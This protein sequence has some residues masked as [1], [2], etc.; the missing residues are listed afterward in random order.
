M[1]SG[2]ALCSDSK[3]ENNVTIAILSVQ[4]LSSYL[5]VTIQDVV[6]LN[7]AEVKLSSF[8]RGKK[9]LSKHEVDNSRALSR[10]R[11]HSERVIGLLR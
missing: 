1:D 10:V 7:H 2:C 6:A 4:Y 9:Q 3:F 5:W 11:I 8:T